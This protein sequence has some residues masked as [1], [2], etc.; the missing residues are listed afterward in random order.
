MGLKVY[1]HYAE[2]GQGPS[3]NG[4]YDIVWKLILDL[5]GAFTPNEI[6]PDIPTNNFGPLFSQFLGPIRTEILFF[7]TK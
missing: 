2:T 4:W 1:S 6:Q 7:N 5:K 3:T